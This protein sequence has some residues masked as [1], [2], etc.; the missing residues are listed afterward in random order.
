MPLASPQAKESKGSDDESPGFGEED[1]PQ[2]Q[3]HPPQRRGAGDLQEG[4]AAQAAA[5]LTGFAGLERRMSTRYNLKFRY[6]G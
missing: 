4:S 6:L 2:L 3:D 5:G 1:V